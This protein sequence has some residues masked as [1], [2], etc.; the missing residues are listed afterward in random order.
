MNL[1]IFVANIRK[2]RLIFLIVCI[3]VPV[4]LALIVLTSTISNTLAISNLDQRSYDRLLNDNLIFAFAIFTLGMVIVTPI[5]IVLNGMF[6]RVLSFTNTLS[7]RDAEKL[8]LLNET[9]P[10]YNKYMPPYIIKGN[11]VTFFKMFHQN[12]IRFDDM[13]R[14]DLRPKFAYLVPTFVKIDTK[15]GI[16]Y[17]SLSKNDFIPKNL[18]A[19][20]L[21]ANPNIIINENWN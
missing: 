5:V 12:T 20:A 19:E 11:T 10:F 6:R 9:E 3:A 13:V 14:I 4:A 18:L 21:K 15:H 17:Y 1:E 16:F 8:V 7:I 2:R